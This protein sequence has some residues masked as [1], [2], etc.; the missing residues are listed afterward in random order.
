MKKILFLLAPITAVMVGCNNGKL[1]GE[2]N[3]AQNTTALLNNNG[4]KS[5]QVSNLQRYVAVGSSGVYSYDGVRW[6]KSLSGFYTDIVAGIDNDLNMP[7]FLVIEQAKD[8]KSGKDIT[9]LMFSYNG[10]NWDGNSLNGSYSSAA[11][12]NN[13]SFV[14]VG[15]SGY[16]STQLYP[17]SRYGSWATHPNG[18]SG[19]NI[20]NHMDL[21]SVVYSPRVVDGEQYGDFIL[22]GADDSSA[23]DYG[24]ASPYCGQRDGLVGFL[25]IMPNG[26]SE[27]FSGINCVEGVGPLTSVAVSPDA[28]VVAD[29]NGNII[30]LDRNVLTNKK[31]SVNGT[32]INASYVSSNIVYHSVISKFFKIKN[33]ND[34]FMAFGDSGEVLISSDGV[35]WT[36][37]NTG[38][39]NIF[40]GATFSADAQEYKM[41]GGVNVNGSNGFIMTSSD[42]VKWTGSAESNIQGMLYNIVSS[43][44]L[45]MIKINGASAPIYLTN[46]KTSTITVTLS[47]DVTIDNQEVS[48]VSSNSDVAK[49]SALNGETC[50]LNGINTVCSFVITA[51]SNGDAVITIANKGKINIPV[52]QVSV[53]V[54]DSKYVAVGD[55]ALL[56]SSS[57]GVEWFQHSDI[58]NYNLNSVNYSINAADDNGVLNLYPTQDNPATQNMYIALGDAGK[59]GVSADGVSWNFRTVSNS[60]L[61]DIVVNNVGQGVR[62]VIVGDKGTIISP[63]SNGDFQS[64][65]VKGGGRISENFVAVTYEYHYIPDVYSA[66]GMTQTG[67]V[68]VGRDST[69]GDGVLAISGDGVD[70]SGVM[71]SQGTY[72]APHGFSGTS[73]FVG[74]TAGNG[75]FVVLSETGEIVT[76]TDSVNWVVHKPKTLSG[77]KM[78][79]INFL[80]GIF[81]ATGQNVVATSNDGL[82]WTLQ[83]GV[84]GKS[85]T[86]VSYS[87][88][89]DTY[90][91]V[92]SDGSVLTSK[93]ASDWQV[94]KNNTNM[95]KLNGVVFGGPSS[96]S[97]KEMTASQ[98]TSW[99]NNTLE[100]IPGDQFGLLGFIV[101]NQSSINLGNINIFGEFPSDEFS[102]DLYRSTCFNGKNKSVVLSPSA[103]CSLVIKYEPTKLD[104]GGNIQFT[105]QAIPEIGSSITKS[106]NIVVP[107]SSRGYSK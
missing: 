97:I 104:F 52:S 45:N 1:T 55:S 65:S 30:K 61:N 7:Q 63:T 23:Y 89:D 69:Y 80:N 84:Y 95:K 49:V 14:V 44:P 11:S 88:N 22:V 26:G 25:S 15:K 3:G 34:R 4:L 33:I 38:G 6:G 79:S 100:N 81:I 82:N 42:G 105:V 76:S 21:S 67:F 98:I 54:Y 12:G 48:M 32:S 78:L 47:S 91:A 106:Q 99:G 39:D 62:Y 60:N 41:V 71:A 64:R 90:L 53:H 92:A 2:S 17:N 57:D 74:V 83:M 28:L 16:A 56:T 29:G 87:S 40:N 10:V 103:S 20:Y 77:Q 75:T 8:E 107:Y 66:K 43:N 24:E 96:L 72:P 31:V 50:T 19:P 5:T 68:A 59:F 85:I 37:Q 101:T 73:G 93:D 102:F 18:P 13:G 35:S 27:R 51:V 36:T 94:V 58:S 70:W 9:N 86:K 46:N